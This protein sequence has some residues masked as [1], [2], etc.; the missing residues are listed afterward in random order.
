MARCTGTSFPA[1]SAKD[2]SKVSIKLPPLSEQQKIAQILT[3]VDEAITQTEKLIAKYQRI[4][5]GLMQ[6]L[7]TK[8]ID[9]N[10]NIRSE[11]THEFKDSHLGRIP[12]EWECDFLPKVAK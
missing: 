4:K 1:I 12:V 10:G 2:L 3:K 7:L 6:D 8:G 11:A 5:T 9:K